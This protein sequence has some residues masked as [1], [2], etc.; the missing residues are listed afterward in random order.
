[1]RSPCG[2]NGQAEAIARDE[3]GVGLNTVIELARSYGLWITL[4]AVFLAMHWFGMRSCGRRGER[5]T[6]RSGSIVG[7]HDDHSDKRSGA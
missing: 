3:N 2:L 1:M 4:G 7:A 5:A 6:G